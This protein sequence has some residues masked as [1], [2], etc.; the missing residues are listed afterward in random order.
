MCISKFYSNI[1]KCERMDAYFKMLFEYY[2]KCE[3]MNVNY[4]ELVDF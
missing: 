3:G 1:T 4:K 2:T